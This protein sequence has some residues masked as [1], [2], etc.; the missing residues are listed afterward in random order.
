MSLLPKTIK[1][2]F[3]NLVQITEEQ[4]VRFSNHLVYSATHTGNNQPY[5]IL[6]FNHKSAIFETNRDLALT[7]YLQEIF[8]LCSRFGEHTGIN[9]LAAGDKT[10]AAT[11]HVESPFLDFKNFA[12]EG[13]NIA[14]VMKYTQS[15]KNLMSSSQEG[16]TRVFDIEKM[17]ED[18]YASVKYINTR[19]GVSHIDIRSESLYA[20]TGKQSIEYYP[21]NWLSTK[22]N[23][24]I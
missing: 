23:E 12:V 11:S 2:T 24:V 3:Q 6:L 20:F 19:F 7:L 1:D 14:F 16:Q 4:L 5:T 18:V 15:F 22:L 10:I 8:F 13:D 21:T 17:I 9:Q